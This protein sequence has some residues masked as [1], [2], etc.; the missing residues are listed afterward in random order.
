MK[1]SNTLKSFLDKPKIQK[2]INQSHWYDLFI[3]YRHYIEDNFKTVFKYSRINELLEVLKKA[4]IDEDILEKIPINIAFYNKYLGKKC[5]VKNL[6]TYNNSNS[7]YKYV[8]QVC[9]IVEPNCVSVTPTLNDESNFIRGKWYIV[10]GKTS[11]IDTEMGFNL[12]II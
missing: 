10:L 2:L 8:G 6:S 1:I 4:N 12:E 5:Y 3:N 11:Q 7:P 9:K